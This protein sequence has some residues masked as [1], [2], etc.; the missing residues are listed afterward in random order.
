MVR[1]PLTGRKFEYTL[2]P[3]TLYELFEFAGIDISTVSKPTVSM[4]R[5]IDEYLLYGGYPGVV[6]LPALS[7][8][9]Q[10]LNELKTSYLTRDISQL[11]GISDTHQFIETATFLAQNSGTILSKENIAKT[12]GI[13]VHRVNSYIEALEKTFVIQLVRPFYK[14]PVKEL[15]HRPKVYFTDTGIRNIL[16]QKIQPSLILSDRGVLFEQA[17]LQL[18]NTQSAPIYFWRTINQTEVDFVIKRAAAL[19]AYEVKYSYL[20]STLPKSLVSFMNTYPSCDTG[21]VVSKESILTI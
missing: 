2:S 8:K 11:F 16:L 10:K 13:S 1:E 5:I 14:N 21:I 12:V 3:V 15:S 7:D 20:R 6:S 18:L 4:Y 17:V 9:I 19:N